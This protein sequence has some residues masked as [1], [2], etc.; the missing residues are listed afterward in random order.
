MLK[1]FASA[2]DARFLLI[3]L[4]RMERALQ[5]T[6]KYYVINKNNLYIKKKYVLRKDL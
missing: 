6:P 2:L 5:M 1:I 3:G 4:S